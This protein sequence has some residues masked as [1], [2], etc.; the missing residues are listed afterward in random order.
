MKILITILCVII[1]TCVA[2]SHHP[3]KPLRASTIAS[4]SSTS[5]PIIGK[6]SSSITTSYLD[7]ISTDLMHKFWKIDMQ[8]K[9]SMG[10]LLDLYES[11]KVDA[12]TFQGVLGKKLRYFDN[13]R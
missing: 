7:K 2:L 5:S 8:T 9:R 13:T 12:S 6:S 1:T 11:A 3:L 4:P 10:K